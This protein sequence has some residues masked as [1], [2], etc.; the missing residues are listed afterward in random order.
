MDEVDVDAVPIRTAPVADEVDVVPIRTAPR[1]DEVL[2]APEVLFRTA[3]LA[4]DAAMFVLLL[5]F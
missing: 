1:A 5:L 4:A 3:P 2:A